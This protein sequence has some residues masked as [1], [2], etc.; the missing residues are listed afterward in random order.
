MYKHSCN[1][2]L[3]YISITRKHL[4]RGIFMTSM[5]NNAHKEHQCDGRRKL[6]LL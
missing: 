3:S 2:E 1:G 4:T 5:A 6:F